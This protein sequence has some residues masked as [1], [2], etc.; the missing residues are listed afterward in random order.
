MKRIN[1]LLA[2]FVAATL[3]VAAGCDREKHAHTPATPSGGNAGQPA[4][5]ATPGQALPTG[6]VLTAAPANAKGVSDVKKDAA[7]DKEVVV[8]GVVAGSL[9]PIAPNLAVFTLAD[10]SLETCD[11]M[12]GDSCKTPWDACCAAS[13]DIVAKTMTIQV[14]GPDGKPLKT[15]LTGT[16]GLAPLKKVTVKGK[17]RSVEGEAGKRAVVVDAT[18]IFVQG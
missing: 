5:A 3:V 12:P 7:K 11:K 15:A 6:L 17:V 1:A 16:A 8:T 2:T 18:G 10:A 4:A 13:S 9:D 14:V